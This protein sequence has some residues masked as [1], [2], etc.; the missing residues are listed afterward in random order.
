MKE[1]ESDVARPLHDVDDQPVFREGW[2]AQVLAVANGLI[3]AERISAKQWTATFSAE[4]AK[5]KHAADCDELEAYYRAALSAL[6]SLLNA[7]SSISIG[8][9]EDRTELWRRA[10]LN[11]P[12]GQP[13]EMAA[14]HAKIHHEHAHQH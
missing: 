6:E 4:L 5:P 2:H 11:T 10:Y 1:H 12:H 9:L 8:D 7:H 14:G 13:V 3:D